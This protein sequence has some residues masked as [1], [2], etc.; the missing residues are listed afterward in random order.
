MPMRPDCL[1][2]TPFFLDV[3]SMGTG[4]AA[5]TQSYTIGATLAH[6]AKQLQEHEANEVLPQI[7]RMAF[8]AHDPHVGNLAQQGCLCEASVSFRRVD[9]DKGIEGV[10]DLAVELH[11]HRPPIDWH[12]TVRRFWRLR[13]ARVR[14]WAP[15]Q[16]V[17]RFAKHVV[18]QAFLHF[19]D[20]VGLVRL[21]FDRPVARLLIGA[22]VDQARF[23]IHFQAFAANHVH[24]FCRGQQARTK[25]RRALKASSS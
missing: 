17:A 14:V 13:R 8:R 11:G 18:F 9:D 5:L 7:L 15:C 6:Q 25:V 22:A 10:E 21:D 24:A 4:M 20:R 12:L 3:A 16:G 2:C 23:A 1:A 19:P